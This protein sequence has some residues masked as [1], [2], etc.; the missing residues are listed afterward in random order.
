M[1]DSFDSNGT[2]NYVGNLNWIK[3]SQSGVIVNTPPTINGPGT[4]SDTNT[5]AQPY[6]HA[7]L[8]RRFGQLPSFTS[9]SP[10]TARATSFIPPAA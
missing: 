10:P 1:H 3:I 4:S 7:Q 5:Q 6:T 2:T 9:A 8:E